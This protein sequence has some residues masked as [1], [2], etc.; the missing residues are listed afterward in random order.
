MQNSSLEANQF[1]I[2]L[3]LL[4]NILFGLSCLIFAQF[5]EKFGSLWVNLYK[6]IISTTCFLVLALILN[7]EI[8]DFTDSSKLYFFFSG[9]IGL[10]LAD[11]FLLTSLRHNGV[12]ETL[13]FYSFQP[14]LVYA[15]SYFLW[16]EQLASSQWVGVFVFCICLFIFCFDKFQKSKVHL[17]YAFMAFF[18]I[19][20]DTTGILISKYAYN[21]APHIDSVEACLFRGL[22][23][24]TGLGIVGI[25]R[26]MNFAAKFKSMNSRSKFLI[27]AACFMGTF[28]SLLFYL[29]AVQI[30]TIT[31]LT[32]V[33]VATPLWATF[34]E[35]FYY[36]K[37]PSRIFLICF[38][39]YLA[40][41]LW[42]F[43]HLNDSLSN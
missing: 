43:F 34:F 19:V 4:S 5:T 11:I 31:I 36:K 40:A 1:A 26:P 14:F 12:G 33:S 8:S 37:L 6:A 41:F 17:K 3:A 24:L 15:C 39:L 20:L 27:S 7:L 23:A 42:N 16:G 2:T 22:G 32:A 13:I 35:F 9:I 38:S 21:F 30:G 25:F 28:L 29:K 18:A 10:A